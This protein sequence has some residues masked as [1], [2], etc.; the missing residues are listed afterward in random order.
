MSFFG[1]TDFLIEVQKGNVPGHTMVGV[2]G[3][4][5]STVGTGNFEDFWFI[6][7]TRSA[8]TSAETWVIRSSSAD[9][10][11]AGTGARTVIVISLDANYDVQVTLVTL[12][13]QTDVT[14]ANTHI[15]TR[16]LVVGTVGGGGVNAGQIEVRKSGGAVGVDVRSIIPTGFS[17][18]QDG[19]Y[20]VPNG[21]SALI[22]QAAFFVPKNEDG[23][24]R[25]TQKASASDAPIITGL[26]LHFY[27]TNFSFD[28]DAPILVPEKTDITFTVSTTNP[29]V[30]INALFS[31]LEIDNTAL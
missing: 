30:N 10:T 22:Q 23:I 16:F 11:S 19:H 2:I 13:G 7:G 1:S 12:N 21:V 6:G 25:N 18:C 5:D 17:L 15:R 29:G 9:D 3:R 4:V 28:A 26:D 8:I 27:Q 31:W 20:T 24:I 14:I